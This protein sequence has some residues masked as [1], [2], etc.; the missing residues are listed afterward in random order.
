MQYKPNYNHEE[1]INNEDKLVGIALVK[2]ILANI[3]NPLICYSDLAR[4]VGYSTG[5]GTLDCHLGN[6]SAFCEANGMPLISAV[7]INKET[8]LPGNG[9][10]TYFYGDIPENKR[11]EHLNVEYAGIIKARYQL[12]KML[13]WLQGQTWR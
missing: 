13:N 5:H 8:S 9:F 6:L 2:H 10:F 11:I 3:Y 7:V 1:I 4:R 12:Q